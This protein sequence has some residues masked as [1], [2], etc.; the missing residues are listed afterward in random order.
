MSSQPNDPPTPVHQHPVAVFAERLSTRLDDL[1]T[2]SLLSMDPAAKRE[3]LVALSTARTQL[4]A[5][6]L[7]LLSDAE[8]TG[9]CAQ[10]GA[11][12]AAGWL[13]GETRQTRLQARSDLALATRLETLPVLSAG[14]ATGGVNTA[15]ARAIV[16]ILDGL[17]TRGEYAVSVDQL[18]AAETHLVDLAAAHDATELKALGRTL[19]E[20]IA[21]EV[22][23]ELLGRALE[24]E[25]AAAARRTTFVMREDDEGTCHGRFRLP[26][27]HGQML[28]KA[29]QSLT[30][31]TRN[32]SVVQGLAQAPI[33]PDLPAPV[34]DG[35]AFTE[36]LE[37][38]DARWLP[39]H[40]GVGATVV[41]TMTLDQLLADL[42]TAGVCTL[43]TGGHLSAAEARR[44]ACRAGIIPMVLGSRSVVLDAGTK[45]RL[46]TE[47]MRLAM[48]VRDRGCTAAGCGRPRRHVPRPPRH[49]LQRRRRHL[50]R[51]RPPPLRPS[52]PP[53]PRPPLHPRHTP[54]RQ[55]H[56]P[57][58]D[59]GATHTPVEQR[60][61][62]GDK[63]HLG[64]E[65]LR[66]FTALK[67]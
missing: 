9:A 34:R 8:T 29:I 28:R 23:D 4:E 33:D 36:I 39:T 19:L 43:D 37:A 30:N 66:R 14:M 16:A 49:P 24:A 1:A 32:T 64:G 60:S 44:L 56:L 62:R 38:V 48:G 41:V 15:Q 20:V 13:A 5:L 47:P 54:H 55:S 10:S 67:G 65:W 50:G 63:T 25:E 35:V 57:P 17:P 27:R 31:P 40:G 21:P 42:D 45:T 26:A 18:A 59:L 53:H 7:R 6:Q 3:T 61:L 52:P 2:V 58:A 22:A 46:H 51:Q 12:T 11:A